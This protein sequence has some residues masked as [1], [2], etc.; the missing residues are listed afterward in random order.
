MKS[1]LETTPPHH[2]KL[3]QIKADH[4]AFLQTKP[5]CKELQPSIGSGT[6]Q[7]LKIP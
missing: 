1:N 6:E 4:I 5:L 2:K 3:D 7:R